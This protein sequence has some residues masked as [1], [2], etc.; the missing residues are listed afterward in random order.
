MA[1]VPDEDIE[2]VEGRVIESLPSA[3][4]RITASKDR[5]IL[6]SLSGRMRVNKIKVLVGDKVTVQI[7]PYSGRGRIVK[8]L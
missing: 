7:D 1:K 3:L 4:F 8:R 6:C 5:V 2:I